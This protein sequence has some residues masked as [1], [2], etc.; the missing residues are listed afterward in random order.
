LKQVKAYG[1][2]YGNNLGGYASIIIPLNDNEGQIR[3]IQYISV[4]SDGTIYKS[5]HTGGETKGNY[6]V[7]GNITNGQPFYVSEG[8]ATGASPH[9]AVGIPVV[10]AFYS[11]NISPVIDNLRKLYPESKITILADD[12]RN[13]FIEKGINPGK[14]AAEKASN[15]YGCHFIL[16]EFP[17]DFMINGK[18]PTDFNDLHVHFGLDKLKEILNKQSQ[19]TSINR[20]S[21]VWDIPTPLPDELPKV[22]IFKEDMLP[23]VL[24]GWLWDIADRMQIPPDFSAATAIVVLSSLIGRKIGILPKKFDDWLVVPN[25]WG[26]IVGRPS[27]LKS[28]AISEVM[29]PLER[30]IADASKEYQTKLSGYELEEMAH[31]ARKEAYQTRL[32]TAARKKKQ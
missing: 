26:A 28:P 20:E 17:D 1:I 7:I 32:K 6:F 14:E 16:P 9:E 25:L 24:Y 30:L 8:Y 10:V 22:A 27:L 21:E 12:D 5:F 4:G 3:S 13:T 29:K 2:R 15:Q 31:K 19:F 18:R 11:G 23:E